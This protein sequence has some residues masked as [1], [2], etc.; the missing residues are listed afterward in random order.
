MTL[1]GSGTGSVRIAANVSAA[2]ARAN[3]RRPVSS[4]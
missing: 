2:V 1:D 3:A 4:S